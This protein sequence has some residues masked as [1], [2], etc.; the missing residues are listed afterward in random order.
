M[1]I[2]IYASYLTLRSLNSSYLD[3]KRW[4]ENTGIRK[5][6]STFSFILKINCMLICTDFTLG[7]WLTEFI[8]YHITKWID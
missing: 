6:S 7:W 3:N 5:I 2:I 1:D 8:E 4:S